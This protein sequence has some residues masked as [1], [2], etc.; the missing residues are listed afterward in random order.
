MGKPKPYWWTFLLLLHE[1]PSVYLP[2]CMYLFTHV[3]FWSCQM[4]INFI[5]KMSRKKITLDNIPVDF[6]KNILLN[7]RKQSGSW[8]YIKVFKILIFDS[9]IVCVCICVCCY[10]RVLRKRISYWLGNSLMGQDSWYK[11]PLN[12]IVLQVNHFF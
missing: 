2:L 5:T 10:I 7:I 9:K 1:N 8:W 11:W 12:Q 3:W 6:I 4:L